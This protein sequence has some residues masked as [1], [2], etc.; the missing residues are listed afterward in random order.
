MDID[1]IKAFL[2]EHWRTVAI[3]SASILTVLAVIA[4]V[5]TSG[6]E[7]VVERQSTTTTGPQD[8]TTQDEATTTAEPG[9]PD[10][11]GTSLPQGAP[12]RPR[13]ELKVPKVASGS[14]PDFGLRAQGVTD[15]EVLLGVSYNKSGC[16]DSGAI[17]AALGSAVTGDAE[18][19]IA[20]YTRYVN[21][22][23][24]IAKGLKL[25]T[26]SYD[27][28]GVCPEKNR[29]AAVKMA[30]EDKVFFAVPGLHTVSDYMLTR[31]VPIFGGR[32]DIRSMAK[33]GANGLGLTIPLG[34]NFEAWATFGV[35]Y[36][37]STGK[38][39][40]LIR[41]IS[42]ASGDWDTYGP[43]FVKIAAAHGLRFDPIIRYDADDAS[44]AQET[45]DNVAAQGRDADCEHVYFMG[46][47]A[48][49]LVFLTDGATRNGWFPDVWTW[50]NYAVLTDDDNIGK[51]MDPVQWENAIGLSTR[52]PPGEHPYE[53]NC[54][55][56][57]ES[58]N[59]NDG[60]SE[61]AFTVIACATI[62]TAAE[63]MRRAVERTSVLTGNSL[64][65]GA[66]AIRNDFFYDAH[67]PIEYRFPS[68]DGP[69]KTKGWSHFTPVK[70]SNAES[71][72][73]FPEY[74]RYWREWGPGN[75]GGEDLRRF[76]QD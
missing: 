76:Y 2:A 50:T 46:G 29:P 66:D 60:Q 57:Y 7:D 15:S 35:H 8:A 13:V 10:D 6:S 65:L 74:P 61:G 45:S 59:G 19:S 26:R 11:V 43:D 51:L 33:I 73:L 25:V 3:A 54:K 34:P 30:D 71:R 12:P 53:D 1:Q 24:G 75:S 64:L 17:E 48:L 23:G 44:K 62:L 55:D 37:K 18:K 41:P 21:D 49:P 14:I 38:N 52:V 28:G 5:T 42:G 68:P 63:Q 9:L 31:D 36:L 27:D 47:N 32:D 56:I 70:W 67:V 4:V 20:T 39:A 16:G 40:C 69:F 72:Y 58:Y 22:S